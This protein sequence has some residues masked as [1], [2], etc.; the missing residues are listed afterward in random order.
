MS[1]NFHIDRYS[2]GRFSSY[3]KYRARHNNR[4]PILSDSEK[5][6]AQSNVKQREDIGAA[7]KISKDNQRLLDYGAELNV[8]YTYPDP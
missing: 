4:D 5:R 7:Q 8:Q 2:S 6:N 3:D 1:V